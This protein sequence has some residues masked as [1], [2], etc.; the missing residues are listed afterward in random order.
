MGLRHEGQRTADL[1]VTLGNQPCTP[2]Q[3]LCRVNCSK[4]CG[5]HASCSLSATV[6]VIHPSIIKYLSYSI[7][8][9]AGIFRDFLGAP[10]KYLSFFFKCLGKGDSMTCFI[11]TVL[12]GCG[13][14]SN[15]SFRII[16][17]Q[18]KLKANQN[19]GR[20]ERGAGLCNSS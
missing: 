5:T 8:W 13:I 3:L 10:G 17:G 7:I 9:L 11:E 19:Q 15:W 2:A 12:I 4:A 1:H 16:K 6:D 14:W 20:A 18:S